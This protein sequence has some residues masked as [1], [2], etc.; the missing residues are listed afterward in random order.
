MAIVSPG[1]FT[2][3]RTMETDLNFIITNADLK[4][5]Q[6]AVDDSLELTEDE[7]IDATEEKSKPA[8]S[9]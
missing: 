5:M 3:M 1:N 2:E 9:A 7:Q 6:E 4:R 8:K